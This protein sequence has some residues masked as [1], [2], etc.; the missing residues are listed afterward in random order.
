[1]LQSSASMIPCTD[2][3]PPSVARSCFTAVSVT[4]FFACDE[5]MSDTR[6]A[7]IDSS[8]YSTHV[9]AG[10]GGVSPEALF[11]SL[12]RYI[13]CYRSHSVGVHSLHHIVN[14][15]PTLDEASPMTEV[16]V[17]AS[18]VTTRAASSHLSAWVSI[19]LRV[20]R[21]PVWYLLV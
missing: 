20:P 3:L 15:P 9:L 7:N 5:H 21:C 18:S 17:W 11:P 1:M 8:Y 4:L 13:L 14:I 19:Y 2:I 10:L 16:S 12:V 6:V